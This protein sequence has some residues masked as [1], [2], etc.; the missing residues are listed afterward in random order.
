M[1]EF[2][3]GV[4]FVVGLILVY[5]GVLIWALISGRR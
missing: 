2:L 4:L 3:M 1:F 5:V